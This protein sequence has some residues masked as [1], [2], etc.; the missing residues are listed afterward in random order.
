[1]VCVVAA[2]QSDCSDLLISSGVILVS[3]LIEHGS[4]ILSPSEFY[5]V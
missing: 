3:V 5:D 2:E 4:L 1:M